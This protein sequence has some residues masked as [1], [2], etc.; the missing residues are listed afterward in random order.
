MCENNLLKPVSPYGVT[1]LAAEH[2]CYLYWKN[3]NVPTISLRYFTVYGPRQRPDMAINK[4]VTALFNRNEII[5]YGNGNQTRDFTFIDDI[6]SAIVLSAESNCL[7]EVFNVGGGSTISIN[8]L[9]NR[10]KYHSGFKAK[11]KYKKNQKGDIKDT[12][13]DLSKI[14]DNLGWEPKTDINKG[15]KKYIKWFKNEY[16][17]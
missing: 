17:N 4:F 1:K 6:L 5:L 9:I 11:I 12:W 7:G 15:L 8:E 14:K 13:A 16:V 2:L 3:Y 10:R